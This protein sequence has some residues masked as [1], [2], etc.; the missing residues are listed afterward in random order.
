MNLTK[1][2]NYLNEKA[3][4]LRQEAD[5][6]ESIA[7]NLAALDSPA[8]EQ[9]TIQVKRR[10]KMSTSARLRISKAQ[11]ARWARFHRQQKIVEMKKR[12]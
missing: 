10:G 11:T 8:T 3:N 5:R 6:I 1:V 4:D 12:A 7:N 9:P 2:V